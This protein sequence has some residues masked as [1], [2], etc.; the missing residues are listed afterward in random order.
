MDP[1]I[2]KVLPK[3][4]LCHNEYVFKK[5]KV[6][7]NQSESRD[8]LMDKNSHQNFLP[9]EV[10]AVTGD[11]SI[12]LPEYLVNEMG[13]YEGTMIQIIVDGNELLLREDKEE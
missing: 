12:H 3:R 11:Y 8:P 6:I 2:Y 9:I 7:Y 5:G 10:D 1:L 4:L 13:W